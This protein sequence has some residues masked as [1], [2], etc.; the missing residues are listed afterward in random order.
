M[1]VDDFDGKYITLLR[2]G[3]SSGDTMSSSGRQG[4]QDDGDE[5]GSAADYRVDEI[6]TFH[7]E[8]LGH[9]V[10]FSNNVREREAK[11]KAAHL[12]IAMSVVPKAP[13]PF[14]SR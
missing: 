3:P 7:R 14:R 12:Q 2:R 5:D 13:T 4:R 9:H 10:S 11:A 1:D 8:W 6:G